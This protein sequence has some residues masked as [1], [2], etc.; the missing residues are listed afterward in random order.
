MVT[1]TDKRDPYPTGGI[2]FR[3]TQRRMP[4]KWIPFL[5]SLIA[6]CTAVRAQDSIVLR[7][8]MRTD[9]IDSLIRSREQTLVTETPMGACPHVTGN[10]WD[11]K[12]PYI[13]YTSSGSSLETSSLWNEN[14][15][16]FQTPVAGV[17]VRGFGKSH[18]GLDVALHTGDSVR[19]SWT[20]V[21]RYAGYDNGGYGKL[22]VVRHCNGLETWYA[23][24]AAWL[25]QPNQVVEKGMV[26]G[27]GG[28]TGRS[29]GPHLHFETRFQGRPMDPLRVIR[30][31]NGRYEFGDLKVMQ[32]ADR[33]KSKTDLVPE[34]T[35]INPS[36]RKGDGANPYP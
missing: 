34:K 4:A 29:T 33:E 31:N 24:L 32:P 36:E 35:G 12:T 1:F 14:R 3:Q 22:V 19:A 10:D 16:I 28:S 20:G 5:V 11:N 21:V 8:T 27:L 15:E 17:F 30:S 6:A 18:K 26:I 23:H 2:R 9:P 13:R 25:V 7:G